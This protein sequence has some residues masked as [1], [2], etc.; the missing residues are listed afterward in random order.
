MNS[1]DSLFALVE[2]MKKKAPAYLD[3][4]TA[5][6]EA[7]FDLA[8]DAMLEGAV[9]KLE[10]NS[11]N[12]ESLSETGLTGVLAAALSVP[13]LHVTQETHSNGH[14]D[15]VIEAEYCSPM[16]RKLG[17]AKVYDGPAYHVAGLEQLLNR[18]TT[19]REGRGLVIS[20]VRKTNIANL[21]KSVREHMDLELPC[22][23]QGKTQDHTWKWAFN[24]TH[25]H[26]CG[27]DLQVSHIACNMFVEKD[28]SSK[29]G[30][31]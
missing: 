26:S 14:V 19:G 9:S 12:Y 16:R 24:S 23:Q 1:D 22:G 4:F 11:K 31:A 6:T 30:K 2:L 25:G 7:E 18:Y 13:G 29:G 5:K 21:V 10:Q 3:L 27:E 15:I 8:F 28:H 20:Y 17:E